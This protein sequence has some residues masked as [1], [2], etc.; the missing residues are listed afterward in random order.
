MKNL[1]KRLQAVVFAIAIVGT[2]GFGAAQA[3]GTDPD[4][5]CPTKPGCKYGGY[6][7]GGCCQLP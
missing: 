6:R 1:N 5:G 7:V 2:L 4:T 3:F